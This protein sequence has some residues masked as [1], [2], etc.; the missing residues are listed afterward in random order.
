MYGGGERDARRFYL[1]PAEL[2]LSSLLG[3]LEGRSFYELKKPYDFVAEKGCEIISG[4][5]DGQLLEAFIDKET[6]KLMK[7][8]AEQCGSELVKI[9]STS[10]SSSAT[11]KPLFVFPKQKRIKEFV[12]S[13][14]LRQRRA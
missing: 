9:I 8:T 4:S 2:D 7:K 5:L 11:P 13:A 1:Y 14:L 6:L 10:L 3:T 12:L